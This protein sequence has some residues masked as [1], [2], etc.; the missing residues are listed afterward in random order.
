MSKT[1]LYIDMDGVIANFN[2]AFLEGLSPNLK[3]PQS[4]PGFFIQLELIPDAWD[5]VKLLLS[6]PKFD[7]YFLSAPSNRNIHSYSEKARY[8]ELHFGH[9]A[10]DR[11]ILATKKDALLKPGVPQY[12]V[13]DYNYVKNGQAAWEQAGKLIHFGSSRF[14][15]WKEVLKYLD[16]YANPVHKNQK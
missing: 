14:P 4:V 12:L 16:S 6:S 5:V 7:T 3:Y 10:L 15:G 13:D 9:E 8:I 11:L 2:K 1:E